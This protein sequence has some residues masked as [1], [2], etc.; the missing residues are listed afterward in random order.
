MARQSLDYG[1]ETAIEPKVWRRGAANAANGKA[2]D[3]VRDQMM[4][5]DPKWATFNSAYINE[6]VEFHLQ[7]AYCNEPT[8]DAL[9]AMLSHIDVMRDPRATSNMVPKEIWDRLE[10]DPEVLEL[11]E[12]RKRLKGGK[13]H[14]YDNENKEK[15]EQIG[16]K[17]RT[18]KPRRV[19]VVIKQ[20]RQFY[21]ENRPTWDIEQ[22]D[23]NSNDELDMD[24]SDDDLDDDF[25]EPDIDLDIPERAELAQLVCKQP[26]DLSDDELTQR[27]IRF[28]ECMVALMSKRETVRRDIIAQRTAAE[29]EVKDS[30]RSSSIDMDAIPTN[31]ST[32]KP[33]VDDAA[34]LGDPFPCRMHKFQCTECIGDEQLLYED[35]T[36]SY[37][38]ASSRNDHFDSRHLPTLTQRLAQGLLKCAH[39]KCTKMVSSFESMDQYIDHQV[40]VHHVKLRAVGGKAAYSRKSS[41]AAGKRKNKEPDQVV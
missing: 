10:L 27:R 35:R 6:H 9:I 24:D 16:K 25:H 7:N 17:I 21:F 33:A 41:P 29:V 3:A 23:G 26:E 34:I 11:E 19:K 5:H 39:P 13:F 22:Q 18:L 15:I 1:C 4:R 28:G 31:T 12:K 30:P 38:R 36:F 20:Y 40:R 14:Y 8:E 32:T 2:P 37:T